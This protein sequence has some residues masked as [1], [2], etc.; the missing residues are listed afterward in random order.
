MRY[1]TFITFIWVEHP[2]FPW[3]LYRNFDKALSLYLQL[4]KDILIREDPYWSYIHF[5]YGPT[6]QLEM[7]A[8]LVFF[9]TLKNKILLFS[10]VLHQNFFQDFIY[11]FTVKIAIQNIFFSP[12]YSK[13]IFPFKNQNQKY[14]F[15]KKNIA[16]PPPLK[17]S[18]PYEWII[19]FWKTPI[20][21]RQGWTF[22]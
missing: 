4:K 21:I 3:R 18:S 11:N 8:V 19:T 12:L 9:L 15:R 7:G 6:I 5:L 2:I 14:I 16:P 10:D 20:M 17:W 22:M 13:I 1:F